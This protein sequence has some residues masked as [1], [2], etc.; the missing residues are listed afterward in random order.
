MDLQNCYIVSIKHFYDGRFSSFTSLSGWL[1]KNCVAKVYVL[2]FFF[3][4]SS[5]SVPAKISTLGFQLRSYFA[6]E[7]LQE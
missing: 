6:D 5:L 1:N 2:S 4:R 7:T 3:A